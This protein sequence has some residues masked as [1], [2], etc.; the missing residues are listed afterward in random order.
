[1]TLRPLRILFV[2]TGNSCRSPMAE[3]IARKLA[4]ERGMSLELKSAGTHARSDWTATPEA[5][6][7]CGEIGVDISGH[8]AQRLSSELVEWADHVLVMEEM[9]AYAVQACDWRAPFKVW[10]MGEFVGKK[11]IDDPVGQSVRRYR[12]CRDL[13][14]RAVDGALERLVW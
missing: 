14:Q 10:K 13:L 12:K 3:G 9:H 8:Q 4:E 1:M 7:V 5:V 2:C 6:Q 11:Q